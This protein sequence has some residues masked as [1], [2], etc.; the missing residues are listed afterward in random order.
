MNN[1]LI[2]NQDIPYISASSY[3]IPLLLQY[4]VISDCGIGLAEIHFPII[5]E[6]L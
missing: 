1:F 4:N 3:S 6:S 5:G 2:T